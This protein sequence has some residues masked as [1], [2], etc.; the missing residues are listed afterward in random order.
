M[1]N[2]L[3]LDMIDWFSLAERMD[4]D[5]AYIRETVDRWFA[6]H[7]VTIEIL[8]NAVRSKNGDDIFLY[9][10]KLKGSSAIFGMNLL[11]EAAAMLE[12]AGRQRNFAK[13][14]ELFM[15]IKREF[16]NV[17]AFVSHPD[18]IELAKQLSETKEEF[19]FMKE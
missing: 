7:A 8:N 10:H 6:D 3:T 1:R 17:R 9:S 4:N 16:E 5:E 11:S 18:W 12:D 13:T 14:D 15:C 19:V 2:D